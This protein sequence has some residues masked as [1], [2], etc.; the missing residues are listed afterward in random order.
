M[1][2]ELT[3]LY[4]NFCILEYYQNYIKSYGPLQAGHKTLLTF[5]TTDHR[6]AMRKIRTGSLPVAYMNQFLQN[7]VVKMQGFKKLKSFK[8]VSVWFESCRY[9]NTMN[10]VFKEVLAATKS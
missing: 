7:Q 10:V 5:L 3:K 8:A 9:Y 6:T 1:C 2:R 4:L